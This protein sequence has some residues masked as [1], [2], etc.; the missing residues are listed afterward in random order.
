MSYPRPLEL[1]DSALK[2]RE[3]EA[4]V[5]WVTMSERDLNWIEALTD[6]LPER[7][8]GVG[9]R[10]VNQVPRFTDSEGVDPSFGCSRSVLGLFDADVHR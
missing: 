1:S 3:W 4:R 9:S 8:T 10:G 5:D 6:V 2:H 7:R